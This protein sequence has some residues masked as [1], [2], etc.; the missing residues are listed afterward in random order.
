MSRSF[1]LKQIMPPLRAIVF[2]L[3]DTL[4]PE[5][6]Y[7]MSGFHAV[8]TWIEAQ[9][10]IAQD[11]SFSRLQCLYHSGV[12]GD[13][14]NQW[15][16]GIGIAPTPWIPQLV[17]VYREHFPQITPYPEVMALLPELRQR[18]RVGLVSDGYLEVQQSKFRALGLDQYFDGVVFSDELGADAW[19]PSSRPFLLVLERLAVAGR[20]A[21]YI[22]DNP[23]K[24][25]IGARKVGMRTVRIR[26]PDGVYAH[27]EPASPE[28][29]PDIEL[30]NLVD[31]ATLLLGHDEDRRRET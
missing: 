6:T 18:F 3:D 15:L 25:F 31:L 16:E 1:S 26:R 19:K 29:V 30:T 27:L 24:D 20:E 21:I 4:Y 22:A 17:K 13:T 9:V 11:E 28:F 14:F 2:D 12:R 5:H 23:Q 8:A 10:G 7:V